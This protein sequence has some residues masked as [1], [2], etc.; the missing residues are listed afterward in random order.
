MLA[1]ELESRGRKGAPD[2]GAV[3][4]PGRTRAVLPQRDN[5]GASAMLERSSPDCSL[6]PCLPRG[7]H[8]VVCY[9]FEFYAIPLC[10]TCS[11]CDK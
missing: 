10:V 3:A 5:S 8:V 9:V 1:M 4:V 2:S 6:V 7:C 11:H